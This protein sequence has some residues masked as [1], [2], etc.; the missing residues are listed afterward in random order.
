MATAQTDR[1]INQ[2]A[3]SMGF[4]T[5]AAH[6]GEVKIIDQTVLPTKTVYLTIETVEQMWEA[7]KT[8]RVRGAPAIGVAA[9][10]GLWI[11]VRDFSE[12]DVAAFRAEVK[13][14]ADYL[15]TSR[16][17]AVNLF[18]ALER[19]QNVADRTEGDADAIKRALWDE[20]MRMLDED[21]AVCRAIGEHGEALLRDGDGVLTHCNAGALATVRYGTAL[22]P[23]YVGKER[24]KTIKVFADETRP[25]LQGARLTAWELNRAGVPV[26]VICDNMSAA[27]MAKG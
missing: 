15:A 16:P 25:L 7:I 14:V 11:G 6:D 20:A 23:I 3:D 10:F 18:W 2:A 24:G 26:T 27:V 12:R 22:A 8:L 5:I 9:A 1:S 19:V 17:T 21:A 4:D 13:R